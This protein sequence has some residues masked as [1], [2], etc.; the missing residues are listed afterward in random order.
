M[1][2]AHLPAEL[3]GRQSRPRT[4][5]TRTIVEAI[6]SEARRRIRLIWAGAIN[7]GK[8]TTWATTLQ[9]TICIV[10][11]R[12]PHAFKVLPGA[13]SWSARSPGSATTAAP[14]VT[15]SHHRSS[16]A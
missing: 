4:W 7:S 2:T 16:R 12:D 14:P 11:K 15:T 9:M 6:L 5:P 8:L 13:G 1:I 10:A 3:L